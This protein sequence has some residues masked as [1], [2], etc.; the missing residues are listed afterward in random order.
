MGAVRIAILAVAAIAAIG[1]AFIVR[2][3]ASPKRPEPAAAAAAPAARPVAQV[4]VAKRDLPIGTRLT[5]ADLAWQAWP[6]DALN[7]SFVTDGAAPDSRYA[8]L[9]HDEWG[10]DAAGEGRRGQ[11]QK[12]ECGGGHAH[13]RS[14]GRAHGRSPPSARHIGAAR[15]RP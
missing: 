11:G 3:M 9:C 13:G 8:F 15:R 14:D 5:P 2:N 6:A 12:Q 1:L 10:E 7:A 4:L